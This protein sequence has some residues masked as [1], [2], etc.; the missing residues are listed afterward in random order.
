MRNFIILFILLGVLG[1]NQP[2]TFSNNKNNSQSGLDS[3]EVLENATNFFVIG[4]WGRQGDFHQADL[5]EMM[6][7]IS[8]VVE[9]EFIVSTGDNFY[10]DGIASVN[11][12]QWQVSFENIY[13]GSFLHVPWY[14]IL[15][16]HD[17][18]GNVQAEI[19]YSN[20]SRR[21]TMPSRYWSE[22]ISMEDDS[23]DAKFVFMDTNPFED[24]Y[25]TKKKY[26]SVIG[27][28]STAQLN[29]FNQTLDSTSSTSWR[30]VVGH[31]PFYSG[32][33]RKDRDSYARQH[34]ENHFDKQMVDVYFCGHEH[35]LQHI[36]KK[37][38]HTTHFI[39]GAGSEVRETGLI[40]GSKFAASETGLLLVSL[41]EKEMLVQFVN[42]KGEVLYKTT[43]LKKR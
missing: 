27:Q 2:N 41:L 20:V 43:V 38:H 18:R 25:Y 19:D 4:D 23:E 9:P 5:G 10:A 21:W 35:D 39:S 42:Y 6:Q 1:C 14:V 17:Y 26:Q 16:N 12:P 7:E 40:E 37:N 29:W 22:D 28:D 34:L 15:G 11:D 32:G 31:H 3:L 8:K 36:K 24:E 30:I 33:K 13:K